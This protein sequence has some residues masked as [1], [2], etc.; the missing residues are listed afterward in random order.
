MIIIVVFNSVLLWLLV[1]FVSAQSTTMFA[2]GEGERLYELLDGLG[3]FGNPMCDLRHFTPTNAC[4][5]V[6]GMAFEMNC[7][8]QGLVAHL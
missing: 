2:A 3:C 5:F 4:G 6:S 8:A 1:E 7:T